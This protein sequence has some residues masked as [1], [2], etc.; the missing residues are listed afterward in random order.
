MERLRFS[1]P[2]DKSGHYPSLIVRVERNAGWGKCVAIAQV[3]MIL[4]SAYGLLSGLFQEIKLIEQHDQQNTT[5]PEFYLCTQKSK[6]S[7]ERKKLHAGFFECALVDA[8]VLPQT[9]YHLVCFKLP[10]TSP[11]GQGCVRQ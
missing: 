9:L 3:F 11:G 1:V 5:I 2:P 10:W 6:R 8:G 7:Q 4:G